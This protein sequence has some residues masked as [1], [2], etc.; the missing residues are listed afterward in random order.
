MDNVDLPSTCHRSSI[1]TFAFRSWKVRW[2]DLDS[3]GGIG[4]L[5]IFPIFWRGTADDLVPRLSVVFRRLLLVCNFPACWRLANV[6]L[7]PKG[8]SSSSVSNYRPISITP[9]LSNVFQHLVYV[10]IRRFIE[11]RIVLPPNSSP[12]GK[13]LA[14]VMPSCVCRTP[15][16]VVWRGQEAGIVQILSLPLLQHQGILVKFC[17][18]W[19]FCAV[20][21]ESVYV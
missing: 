16:R 21:S 7:I 9:I 11:C 20:C 6:T 2:L 17:G 5:A 3:Y 18:S 10:H 14:L 15:Y 13:F 8:P 12:I 4:P 1:L 19:R